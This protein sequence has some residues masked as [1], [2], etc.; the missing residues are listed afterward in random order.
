MFVALRPS[1]QLFHLFVSLLVGR[2]SFAVVKNNLLL[3][4]CMRFEYIMKLPYGKYFYCINQSLLLG[5]KYN[6]ILLINF[7]SIVIFS[8]IHL[9]Y[10]CQNYVTFVQEVDDSTSILCGTNSL[11]PRCITFPTGVSRRF[12]L[13]ITDDHHAPSSRPVVLVSPRICIFRRVVLSLAAWQ[14]D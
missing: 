7:L 5:S 8:F 1:D 12:F 2:A 4:V 3:T 11:F 14:D 6:Q 9:Q 13:T 10:F